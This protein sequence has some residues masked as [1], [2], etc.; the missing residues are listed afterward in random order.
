MSDTNQILTHKY[1]ARIRLKASTALYVGSGESSFTKDAL[2]Q[3]DHN[4]LPMIQGTSLAGALRHAL[5]ESGTFSEEELKGIFGYQTANEGLGSRLKISSAYMLINETQIAEG[6]NPIIDPKVIEK[7]ENL[8]KRQHVRINDK[9]TADKANN[10]LFDN[11]VVYKGTRFVFEIE[12]V[13]TK[14][15]ENNWKKIIDELNNTFFRIGGNTRNG[16]GKLEIYSIYNQVFDLESEEDLNNYRDFDPSFNADLVFIAQSKTDRISSATKYTLNLNL[17]ENFFFI[18]G[19]GFSDDDVDNTPVT[20]EVAVYSTAGIT[21]ETQTLIPASSIKGAISHRTCFHYNSLMKFW[22][23]NGDGKVGV[24]NNA[25]REIFGQEADNETGSKGNII[26]DDIYLTEKEVD[27]NKIFNHVAIDRFTGGAMDGA[28]F[29]EKVTYIKKEDK[30]IKLDIFL[31][32][33]NF[34]KKVLEAFEEALI[35]ICKG[36]LPLGG[37][38]TKGHGIFTGSLFKNDIEIFDYNKP[39]KKSIELEQATI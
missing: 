8:P 38:T 15:D 4:D 28:L 33:N 10:G 39:K 36:H 26:L 12:L 32:K 37:M 2:V 18:F 20:E 1:I 31:T 16:L 22:A 21:F 6:L 7:Y 5:Q 19:S 14:E 27:N 9:G 23:E 34:S 3:K 17:E 25:V 24:A 11:E 30:G 13:G 35:D 29:S